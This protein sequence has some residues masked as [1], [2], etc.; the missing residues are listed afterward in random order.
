MMTSTIQDPRPEARSDTAIELPIETAPAAA[1][2]HAPAEPGLESRIRARHAEL[3]D[4]L[5]E[6]KGDVRLGATEA[7]AKLKAKLADLTHIVTWGVVDGWAN[8]SGPL[9]NKLEQWL[10]ESARHLVRKREQP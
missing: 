9:T 6:L 4:K 5:G 3:L 8:L 2:P 7:R 10:A 1:T